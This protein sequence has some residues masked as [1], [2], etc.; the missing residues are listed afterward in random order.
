[1]RLQAI[2]FITVLI[3]LISKQKFEA[4]CCDA[5]ARSLILKENTATENLIEL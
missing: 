5:L 1:M 2:L 3:I 4:L